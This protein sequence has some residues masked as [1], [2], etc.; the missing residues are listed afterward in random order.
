[1][2]APKITL[3]CPECSVRFLAAHH[4]Q[5]FC[6]PAHSKAYSN[7]QL[8]EGQRIVAV[9]KAWRMSRNAKSMKAVGA[10]AFQMLCQELDALNAADA[11][12][13]RMPAVKVYARRKAAGVL[14]HQGP[15]NRRG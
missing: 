6:T 13:G 1:M 4:R 12:A 14:E 9:A 7:R 5:M 3:T 2:T 10:E 11:K 15:V 8:A